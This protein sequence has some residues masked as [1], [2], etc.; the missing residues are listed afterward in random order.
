M[1]RVAVASS[2]EGA[3]PAGPADGADQWNTGVFTGAIQRL[4]S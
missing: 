3:G 4:K 1:G 2:A